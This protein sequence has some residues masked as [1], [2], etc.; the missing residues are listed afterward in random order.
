MAT[1]ARADR[2]DASPEG[3]GE[4]ARARAD[5]LQ[6]RRADL[7]GGQPSTAETV[8]RARLRADEALTRATAAH[9][10]SAQRHVDAGVAHRRAA[11]AHEQAAMS[12]DDASGDSHQS[13]AERHR[14]E[15]DR[16]EHAAVDEAMAEEADA[17]RR[18]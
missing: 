10:A 1:D 2:E 9:H 13:A 16:H 15:A 7:A 3:R 8:K 4:R 5:E 14:D 11:A 12:A 18:N 6:Q 17:R